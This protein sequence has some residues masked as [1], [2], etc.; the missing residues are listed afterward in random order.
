MCRAHVDFSP[1]LCDQ[2]SQ[3]YTFD[4]INTT[5]AFALLLFF[6]FFRKFV[7]KLLK[8]LQII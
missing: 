8:N 7:K 2:R 1:F 4:A 6:I 3:R 5:T